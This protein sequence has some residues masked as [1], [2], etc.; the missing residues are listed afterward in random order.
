MAPSGPVLLRVLMAGGGAQDTETLS[1]T[2][3]KELIPAI[4]HA[5]IE[6]DPSL[7]EL[8][9]ETLAHTMAALLD[10]QQKTQ[11]SSVQNPDLQKL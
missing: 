9:D 5:N 8:S 1:P 11:L 2:T 6:G 4:D 10:A 7:L 3:C